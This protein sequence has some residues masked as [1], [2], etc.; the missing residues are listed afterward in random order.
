M[1]KY[2][3]CQKIKNHMETLTEKLIVNEVLERLETHLIVDFITKLLLIAGKDVILIVYNK[4]SKMMYFI[5]II[6]GISV[7]ELAWL[8]RDNI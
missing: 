6:E 2:D 5:A 3:L 7:K 1:D 8:F 4:L